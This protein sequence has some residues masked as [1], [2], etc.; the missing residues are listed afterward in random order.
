M[1]QRMLAAVLA[2]MMTLSLNSPVFATG[3]TEGEGE[4]PTVTETEPETG[5]EGNEPESEP[6]TGDEG[7]E[8]ESEPETGD[9][10]EEP[11]SEPETGDEGGEPESE[12]ETGDEVEEPKSEPETGDEGDEPE[13]EPE[14]GDEGEEPDNEPETGDEGEEPESE[15]ETGDE[16]NEPESEPETGDEGEE[17]ESEPETGDDE[18]LENG[19]DV[20]MGTD[21]SG[22]MLLP[23]IDTLAGEPYIQ[24]TV[25]TNTSILINPYQMDYELEDGTI[26][27][28][29]IIGEPGV[30]ESESNVPLSISVEAIG[31]S[32]SGETVFTTSDISPDETRKAVFMYLELQSSVDGLTPD[33]DWSSAYDADQ[34]LLITESTRSMSDMLVMDEATEDTPAYAMFRMSGQVVSTP[35]YMWN[36]DDAV[37][38]HLVF[39]F[40]PLI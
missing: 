27:N 18:E 12:P 30:I 38:V 29:P 20:S 22:S 8:P 11:E 16:G 32:D 15:P 25:P 24:V 5:D 14:T 10:G 36:D 39:T 34:H 9:E 35:T 21:V 13:S 3:E 17:P 2:L 26:C 6:E 1:K 31:T 37:S 23:E 7:E 19:E 33:F 4:T 28:D 40:K